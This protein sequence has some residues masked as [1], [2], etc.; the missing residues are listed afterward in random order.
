MVNG[1]NRR[2]VAEQYSNKTLEENLL[3]KDTQPL[4]V[5]NENEAVVWERSSQ[6]VKSDKTN[7]A[8]ATN[9]TEVANKTE[10]VKS[11]AAPQTA[12]SL[13]DKLID[14]ISYL[15]RMIGQTISSALAAITSSAEK[16]EPFTIAG[17]EL[18]ERAEPE[19]G[20]EKN[21]ENPIEVSKERQADNIYDLIK[22][23]DVE[24]VKQAVS[25][26]GT[27]KLAKNTDKLV[28]YNRRGS[29]VKIDNRDKEKLLYGNTR[30][31][32]YREV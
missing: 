18:V 14:G 13:G 5:K 21:A 2:N 30:Q 32:Y 17:I 15:V 27:R 1:V 24:G 6:N 16:E 10:N 3:K 4:Y 25:A 31:N 11:N 19:E 9:K 8:E 29:I 20:T 12:K 23:G 7:K 26:G 22:K 28:T